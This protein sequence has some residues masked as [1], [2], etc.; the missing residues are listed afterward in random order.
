M[1]IPTIQTEIPKSDNTP[2]SHIE[3]QI[4]KPA[5]QAELERTG[6]L[7]LSPD[8]KKTSSRRRRSV[9]NARLSSL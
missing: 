7:D 3:A 9:L 8:E 5:A 1:A 4:V 6:L 2:T